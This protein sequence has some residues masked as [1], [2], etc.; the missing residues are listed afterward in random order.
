M[1]FFTHLNMSKPVFRGGLCKNRWG[2]GRRGYICRGAGSGCVGFF[3]IAAASQGGILSWE[4]GTQSPWTSIRPGGHLGWVPPT[5]HTSCLGRRVLV[6]QGWQVCGL[7]WRM[8][9]AQNGMCV[10]SEQQLAESARSA[11]SLS[12]GVFR[13][14]PRHRPASWSEDDTRQSPRAAPDM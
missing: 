6:P 5:K 7:V 3:G 11:C 2:V 8:Q 10:T 14:R 13:Q 9:R 4:T 12:L 1:V